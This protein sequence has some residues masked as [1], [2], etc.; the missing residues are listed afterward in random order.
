MNIKQIDFPADQYY[1]EIQTKNQIVLHHTVSDP[2]SVVG[3]VNSWLSD[4]GRIATYIIIS[5]D[6]TINKCFKSNQWAHHIGMKAGTLKSL[7][8]KDYGTRNDS[9]NKHSIA[10]EID[11][12]GGLTKGN[13]GKLLNAYGRPI[14]SKLET[15]EVN[16][17]GYK[18]FQKYSQAQLDAL[19]ELLPI[20][21]ETYGI[22]S[23]GIKD[24]NFDVRMD[25]LKGE[26]GIYSHSSYRSD[27]SDLY[28]DENIVN[29][30]N[31]L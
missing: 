6:G 15:I 28:P 5:Y 14:S 27:K 8:F 21:M 7:G 26:S 17:R 20:L 1:P 11:A 25:A 22:S 13:D 2:T 16:W 30:L 4:K 18:Y 23:N 3:D 9:L 10:I 29:L 12:W 24:G 31:S 19:A